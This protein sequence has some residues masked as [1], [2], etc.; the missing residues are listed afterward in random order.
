[1]KNVIKIFSPNQKAYD[2]WAPAILRIVVGFGFFAHGIAKMIKGPEGFAKL[3]SQIKVPAPEVLAWMAITV[4][5]LGGLALILGILVSIVS[6]PLIIT[7]LTALFTIHYKFG[8][9]SVKTISL[10]E[11]GPKFGPPGY[12]I[13]LLYIATLLI[14][15]EF[16]AGKLSVDSLTVKRN[17]AREEPL[18]PDIQDCN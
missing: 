8:Y 6:I 10:D 18:Q 2:S 9:S 3:L 14:L 11:N 12:E 7:M 1:M 5:V 16:G 15:I 4:E 13:N 17:G